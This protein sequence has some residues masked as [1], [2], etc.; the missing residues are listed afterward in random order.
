MS[1]MPD[2]PDFDAPKQPV[3]L[4]PGIRPEGLA[5]EIVTDP[6]ALPAMDAAPSIATEP[7]PGETAGDMPGVMPDV[8]PGVTPARTEPTAK[9]DTPLFTGWQVGLAALLATPL[10]GFI[11]LAMN[12]FR[13]NQAADGYVMFLPGLIS[14]LAINL[15][16]PLLPASAWPEL[17]V[18]VWLMILPTGMCALRQF[19]YDLFGAELIEQ[20]E[21][22]RGGSVAEIAMVVVGTLILNAGMQYLCYSQ[23]NMGVFKLFM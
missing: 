12:H 15:L 8:M 4:P 6:G 20:E 22:K 16:L 23:W 5:S 3:G 2:F 7:M 18:I 13:R 10:A 14:F 19:D 9:G 11:L 21:Q 1:N 17:H